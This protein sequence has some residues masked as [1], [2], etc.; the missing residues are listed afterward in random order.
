[1]EN[2]SV[3]KLPYGPNGQHVGPF[4]LQLTPLDDCDQSS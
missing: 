4:D 3:G 1:M 2:H